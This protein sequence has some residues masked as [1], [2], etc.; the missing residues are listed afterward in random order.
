MYARMLL[1][2]A[3]SGYLRFFRIV[4]D[5]HEQIPTMVAS[6]RTTEENSVTGKVDDESE[7]ANN[8]PVGTNPLATD[9]TRR[10]R[11]ITQRNSG[12]RRVYAPRRGIS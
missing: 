8:P 11:P 4:L 3:I 12:Q 6:A 9:G 7:Y 1:R 10:S 2:R 5:E